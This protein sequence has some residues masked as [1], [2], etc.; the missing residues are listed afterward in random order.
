MS[1]GAGGARGASLLQLLEQ[2]QRAGS[3]LQAWAQ[4]EVAE[5]DA[6]ASQGGRLHTELGLLGAKLA[7][8]ARA[9]E[10]AAG[11]GS[12]QRVR[13][14]LRGG[15]IGGC[16]GGGGGGGGAAAARRVV[17]PAAKKRLSSAALARLRAHGEAGARG[18]SGTA[19]LQ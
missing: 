6:L 3:A 19:P 5:R 11:R 15:A 7:G 13:G 14:L 10:P 12:E 16:G 2:A 9:A 18:A 8:R 17:R 1:A 4:E